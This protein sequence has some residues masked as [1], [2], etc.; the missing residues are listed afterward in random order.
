[1][2]PPIVTLPVPEAS[3]LMIESL[4][5]MLMLGGIVVV[6]FALGPVQRAVRR[7]LTPRRIVVVQ[8]TTQPVTELD[9]FDIDNLY[10][11]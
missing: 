2:R 6:L 11:D 10:N 4:A 1:M 7:F 5:P 8:Q 9:R 3:A